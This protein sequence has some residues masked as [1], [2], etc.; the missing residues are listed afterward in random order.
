[1][2]EPNHGRVEN[3]L[4]IKNEQQGKKARKM[5]EAEEIDEGD[6]LEE[7]QTLLKFASVSPLTSNCPF[8]VRTKRQLGIS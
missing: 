4:E 7:Q 5:Q 1:M 6:G 3:R 8:L 2:Q